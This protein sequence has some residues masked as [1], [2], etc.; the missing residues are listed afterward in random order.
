MTTCPSSGRVVAK[1]TAFRVR[2]GPPARILPAFKMAAAD[3][4]DVP[5]TASTGIV[6]M[7]SIEPA[8][9]SR[10]IEPITISLELIAGSTFF[11][12]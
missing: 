6:S 12:L 5:C 7:G 10:E 4:R 2:F 1:W 8:T 9:R 11:T 3:A